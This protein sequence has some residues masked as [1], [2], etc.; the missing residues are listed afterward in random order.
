MVRAR[1]DGIDTAL[2]PRVTAANTPRCKI[3]SFYYTVG[4]DCL[5]CIVRATRIKPAVVSH[6][7]A[8]TGFV[9][10]EKKN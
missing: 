2:M 4:G 6:E 5:L 8:E 7:R 3:A 10:G 9:A 1:R